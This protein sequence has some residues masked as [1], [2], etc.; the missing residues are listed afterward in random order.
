MLQ[1]TIWLQISIFIMVSILIFQIS[2]LIDQRQTTKRVSGAIRVEV[3]ND[4]SVPLTGSDGSVSLTDSDKKDKSVSKNQ[5]H[6]FVI[7]RV[8]AKELEPAKSESQSSDDETDITVIKIE[9]KNDVTHKTHDDSSPGVFTADKTIY[10]FRFNAVNLE[11]HPDISINAA[12]PETD[13]DI[14]INA[15]TLTPLSEE[16]GDSLSAFAAR[17]GFSCQLDLRPQISYFNGKTNLQGNELPQEPKRLLGRETLLVSLQFSEPPSRIE[18]TLGSAS[19]LLYGHP[20][21]SVYTVTLR[22]PADDETLNWSHQRL[23][24]PLALV[25]FATPYSNAQT[26]LIVELPG[27][28]ITGHVRHLVHVQPVRSP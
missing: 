23:A 5:A 28:E 26:E 9:S 24:D 13:S 18:L 15:D 10:D 12:S 19:I 22:A 17:D 21:R 6:D 27:I 8:Y 11:V 16:N 14:S 20:G 3:K 2:N 4:T 1:K 7:R 25:L